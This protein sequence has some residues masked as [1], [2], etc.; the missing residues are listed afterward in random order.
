MDIDTGDV[1]KWGD[2]SRIRRDGKS[3]R[4]ESQVR[5]LNH[6]GGNFKSEIVCRNLTRAEALAKEQGFVN[7]YAI[8]AMRRDGTARNPLGNKRPKYHEVIVNSYGK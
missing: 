5:K 8:G 6:E 2:Y 1:Y 3:S 4:A 7:A